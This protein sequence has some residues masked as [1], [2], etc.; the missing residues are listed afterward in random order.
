WTAPAG[1][2]HAI[3]EL[4]FAQPV[5]FNRTRTTEWLNDGQNIQSYAIEAWDGHGWNQIVKAQA[6][7][8]QKVD[9]FQPVTA[10]RV[11]LRVLSSTGTPSIREF[12]LFNIRPTN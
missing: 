7:G 11:R 5:T 4:G 10:S 9:I 8:H 2:H 6:I 12:Q 1:S 3:L